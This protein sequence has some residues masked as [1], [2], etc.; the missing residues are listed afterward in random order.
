MKTKSDFMCIYCFYNMKIT[1][2][3]FKFD[4][5]C[6]L[7]TCSCLLSYYSLESTETSLTFPS[8]QLGTNIDFGYLY[9]F[10]Y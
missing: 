9:F 8:Q 1:P 4:Y 3:L 5:L 7:L 2:S 10:I 6:C